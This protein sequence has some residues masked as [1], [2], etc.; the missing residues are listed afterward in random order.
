MSSCSKAVAS[1]NFYSFNP[2]ITQYS[3]YSIGKGET[4]DM[5]AADLGP[6]MGRSPAPGRPEMMEGSGVCGSGQS[7]EVSSWELRPVW[8]PELAKV[9]TVQGS[10]SSLCGS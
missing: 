8:V 3:F 5:G 6:Q 4:W 7:R 2:L 9:E 1:L 10:S